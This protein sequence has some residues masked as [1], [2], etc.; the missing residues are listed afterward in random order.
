L[1]PLVDYSHRNGD[2]FGPDDFILAADGASLT[3]PN[4]WVSFIAYRSLIGDGRVFRFSAQQCAGC[5]LAQACR[6]TKAP[7]DRMRQV[8]ISNHRSLLAQARTYQQTDSFRQDMKLRAT[9]ERIIAQLVRYF[10]ARQA[11]YIGLAKND[12]QVKQNAMALG[13]FQFWGKG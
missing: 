6:G 7:P 12:Y 11:R 8:F 3:C 4:E 10:G 1:A 2:R 9:I 5:P 13:A